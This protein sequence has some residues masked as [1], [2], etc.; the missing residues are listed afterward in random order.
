VTAREVVPLANALAG[1]PSLSSYSNNCGGGDVINRITFFGLKWRFAAFV[2]I[3]AAL[4]FSNGRNLVPG[5]IWVVPG[6]LLAL[7]RGSSMRVALIGL[8]LASA[9]AGG[10]QWTGV[11]PL[12]LPLS[13]A[14]AV[15]LGSVLGLP[16]AVDRLCF[17]R[18]PVLAGLFVFPLAQVSLE[19]STASLLPYASFGAWA[20]TQTFAPTII[21]IASLFGFWSVSFV[22]ALMAP[23]I[24]GA[25]THTRS[26]RWSGLAVAG[27][28]VLVTLAFG[29]WR[30]ASVP[31]QAAPV[32]MAG[33][34]SKPSDL[35]AIIAA[36]DGC[37]ADACAKARA[38]AR[39]QVNQ[40]FRRTEAAARLGHL[41]FVTWSEAAAPLFVED[42]PAFLDRAKGVARR[43]RLYLAPAVFIVEPGH[44]PWRNAVY[45][46]DP[47]G[48]NIAVHVKSKPVPGEI[49]VDGPDRLA[50]ARTPMGLVGLAIC[51]DMDFQALARQASGARL[52]LVPGSDWL[53]IDPLHPNMVA[54]R[55]VENGYAVL[56]PSR[57]SASVA[58]DGFGREI[59]RTEW[60]GV[61]EPT[62]RATLHSAAPRTLYSRIRDVFAYLAALAFVILCAV[63]ALSS[64]QH[65]YGGLSSDAVNTVAT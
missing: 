60:Q 62:V 8:M 13:I 30:L 55:A 5:L 15:A 12:S 48:R 42:L 50:I 57:E 49:S 18:L 22:I 20:Y 4:G 41:D 37:E 6:L 28:L 63:A 24:A 3:G 54:L 14:S 34:A 9:V 25:L 21:Q 26:Q 53:A 19:L 45:L 11:V 23:A 36:K 31:Q 64:P 27:S 61:D 52:M 40:L 47:G 7:M 65:R 38:D 56:R 59:G 51:Y 43:Y 17:N 58:F 46:F 33:L 16:Y 39:D 44:T 35:T 2:L 29:S 32:A 10:L 1:L